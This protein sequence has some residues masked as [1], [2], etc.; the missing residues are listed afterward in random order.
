[1]RK[2]LFAIFVSIFY[3][4]GYTQH[5]SIEISLDNI[6][7]KNKFIVQRIDNIQ[8]LS[9]GEHYTVFKDSKINE[10]EYKTGEFT[11]TILD[12]K[13]FVNPETQKNL[14]LDDYAISNDGNYILLIS[15]TKQIYRHSNESNNYVLNLKTNKLINL[16]KTKRQ[17]LATFSPTSDKIAY[18]ID[19]NIFC[20]DLKTNETIQITSD[21]EKNKIINGAPD[22]V[23]EEEFSFSK[24]F[25][26]SSDGNKIGFMRF[27]ESQVKEYSLRTYSDSTYPE[28]STYKYPKAGEGN[29]I[30]SVWIYDFNKKNKTKIYIGE[31]KDQYIPR[32]KWSKNPNILSISRLNRLQNKLEFLFYNTDE[33]E[34]N[35]V[36]I[37]EDKYFINEKYEPYFL[38][39]NSFIVISEDDSY[40]H[41]YLFNSNGKL[42]NQITKGNWDVSE[43]IGIDEKNNLVYYKSTEDGPQNNVLYSIQLDGTKKNKISNDGITNVSFSSNYKYFISN[44]S[45]IN[46]P[47]VFS[48]NSSDGK[49]L[50]ILED[51]KKLNDSI[52]KFNFSKVEF[53][54][55]KTSQNIELNGWIIKPSDFNPNKKHPV[56]FYVYGG[57]GSKTVLNSWM[58]KRAW[59][60]MLTQKGY[61]IVSVDGR[62]TTCRG[63]E[64]FKCFYKELGV[65]ETTDQIEAAK[66]ISSLDYVDKNRIGIWGWSFGGYETIMC[67]LKGADYFKMG[68]AVAPVTDWRFYD[69]IYTER[70]MRTPIENP[71][72]YKSSSALLQAKNL[73][74]KLLI[75][76]G[77]ADDNVHVQN[78]YEFI[79]ALI[80]AEKQFNIM[81][82]P[83]KNH[84]INGGNTTYHL[85]TKITDFIIQNL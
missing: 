5:S 1:M 38:K 41:L 22:W 83:N 65:V 3:F 8:H 31:D 60:Q 77:E 20:L 73:N 37:D 50:K 63:E 51:N 59:F 28:T 13:A 16:N 68:V 12:L 80:K 32:I 76:H 57:P 9:D 24:A 58:S 42:K 75:I 30:V 33:N 27:D 52:K 34:E 6:W 25:D 66:Y 62:G 10:Y 71:Q 54:N 23:Y 40:S 85:Y 46:T 56:L 19:N 43:L 4:V 35:V 70:Y 7:K 55:F 36:F 84:F 81:I 78:T 44:Y 14:N 64:F 79:N 15:D 39:D 45:N 69:N 72:G 74:G 48:I 47:P 67:L 2:I 61:I 21:G 11:K 82:Y 49:I 29:S 18:L 53:F 26:W 17:S